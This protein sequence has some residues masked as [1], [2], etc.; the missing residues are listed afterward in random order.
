MANIILRNFGSEPELDWVRK[1][2]HFVDDLD[3][4]VLAGERELSGHK[5]V[6]DEGAQGYGAGSTKQ[7]RANIQYY[8]TSLVGILLLGKSAVTS[9]LNTHLGVNFLQ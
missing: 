8:Y 4:K 2:C 5:V 3:G 9:D 1:S 6:S 7:T